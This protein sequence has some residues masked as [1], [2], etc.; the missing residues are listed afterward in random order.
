MVTAVVCRQFQ[1][2]LVIVSQGY[3]AVLGDAEGRSNVTPAW[4]A[5]FIHAL[6][7]LASGRLAVILEVRIKSLSVQFVVY[8]FD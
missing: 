7:P 8:I 2:E 6:K 1:P 4:Y 3:D 5:H